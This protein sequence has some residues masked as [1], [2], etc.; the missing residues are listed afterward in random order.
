MKNAYCSQLAGVV[1]FSSCSSHTQE[2]LLCYD[3]M[4]TEGAH[5]LPLAFISSSPLYKWHI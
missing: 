4:P 5:P 1:G 2:M 3:V